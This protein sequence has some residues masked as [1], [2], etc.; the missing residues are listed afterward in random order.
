MGVYHLTDGLGGTAVAGGKMK[1]S[2]EDSPSWNGTNTSGFSGLAGG[3]GLRGYFDLGDSGGFGH[4]DFSGAH[5][6]VA[7]IRLSGK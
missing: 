5:R 4:F 7:L 3:F 6:L 1:S 2:P